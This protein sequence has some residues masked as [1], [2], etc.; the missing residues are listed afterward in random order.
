[1]KNQQV[2]RPDQRIVRSPSTFLYVTDRKCGGWEMEKSEATPPRNVQETEKEW[3]G[4]SPLPDSFAAPIMQQAVS[5]LAD[6]PPPSSR[7]RLARNEKEIEKTEGENKDR[8]GK[9]MSSSS[10]Y[11]GS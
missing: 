9:G 6:D 10:F 4:R 2:R 11:R 1:M 7:V 8:S 3:T 5:D